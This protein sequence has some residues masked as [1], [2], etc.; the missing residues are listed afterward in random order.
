[1]HIRGATWAKS[2]TTQAERLINR[3]DEL[4]IGPA[5]KILLRIGAGM[6]PA[7]I[8]SVLFAGFAP[9]FVI[10][11]IPTL[12]L[13]ARPPQSALFELTVKE[14]HWCVTMPFHGMLIV[15]ALLM[16]FI[17]QPDQIGRSVGGVALLAAVAIWPAYMSRKKYEKKQRPVPFQSAY[18]VAGVIVTAQQIAII[19][20]GLL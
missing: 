12:Y 18:S 8:G 9:A 10:L 11:T 1:M 3:I 7:V 16:V 20:G 2:Y 4:D 14:R 13:A 17:G 5:F 15:W 6:S 19:I